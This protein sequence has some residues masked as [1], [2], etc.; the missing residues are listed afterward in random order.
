MAVARLQRSLMDDVTTFIHQAYAPRTHSAYNTH[1]K[2]YL[3]FCT[4]LG[5]APVPAATSTLCQYAAILARSMKYSSVKQYMNIVRILHREWNLPNPMTSNY[6]YQCVMRGIR[7]HLGDRPCRKLPITPDLLVEFLSLLDLSSL[8]DCALWAAMLL[9][10]YGLLR[11]AS[12]LCGT[13]ACTHSHHINRADLQLTPG[14]FQ[15]EVRVTKTTQYGQRPLVVPIPRAPR[16]ALCPTQALAL[17]LSRA[18]PARRPAA[19]SPLFIVTKSAQPLT[20]PLFNQRVHHLLSQC[21]KDRLLYGGHSFRRG[22]ACHAYKVGIPVDTIRS[23]GCWASNAYTAYVLP[24]RPLV[25]KAVQ[26]MADSTVD[27]SG[28]N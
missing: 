26:L 25:A 10:F 14:G 2:S 21:G 11:V 15:V 9:T 23:L 17:Y 27:N 16:S 5:V 7:R 24:D 18:G 20:A 13:T 19:D 1:R 3:A 6:Q 12:V 28:F 8:S 4:V 22:G